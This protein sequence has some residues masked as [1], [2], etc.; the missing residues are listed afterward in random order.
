MKRVGMVAA[1]AVMAGAAWG[2]GTDAPALLARGGS[3]AV[4]VADYA[5]ALR[6][7]RGAA[8]AQEA[9][10]LDARTS[11]NEK[12]RRH[13]WVRLQVAEPRL[14]FLIP[15]V[16]SVGT[17]Y[18]ESLTASDNLSD[19]E[20]LARRVMRLQQHEQRLDGVLRSD[21]RMRGSDILYLQERLF[22]AS[23]DESL[24]TQQR[25]DLARAARRS[26][27]VVELFEPGSLP[28]P[29]ASAV[30]IA[31]RFR[32]AAAQAHA[33]WRAQAARA[34]TA[35]AYGAVF[36]P[37]WVPLL[38][39]ALLLLV[40]LWHRRRELAAGITRLLSS[41]VG[42]LRARWDARHEPVTFSRPPTVEGETPWHS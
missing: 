33:L 25:V 10:L 24:L 9:V 22:R 13:G 6:Q 19:S 37:L 23:V 35:A 21:R 5:A 18:S 20:A 42:W 17:L 30:D 11:V 29:A 1:A 27:L 4:K 39:L 2:Q 15:A 26:T 40:W 28:P 3:V 7:V 14:A 36:A 41:T 8:A 16:E 31:G 32:S 34:A 38:V 12:G